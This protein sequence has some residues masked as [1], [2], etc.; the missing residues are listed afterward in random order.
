MIQINKNNVLK[1]SLEHGL[2]PL[3]KFINKLIK[4]HD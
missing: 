3:I 1:Q 4:Y 2:T